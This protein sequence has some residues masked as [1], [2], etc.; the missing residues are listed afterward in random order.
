MLERITVLMQRAHIIV[1]GLV[2]GVYFRAFTKEAADHLGLIGWVRN[3]PDGSVEAVTEGEEQILKEFVLCLK[4]GPLKARV[5][6]V[7]IEY[8]VAKK[9]FSGF[10]I[11]REHI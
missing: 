11:R 1:K 4:K 10:C 6:E 7:Q 8:S 5:D 9:E 2:Q 3:L